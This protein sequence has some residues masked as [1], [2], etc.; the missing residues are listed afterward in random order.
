MKT[1]NDLKIGDY[2]FHKC[3]EFPLLVEPKK[4]IKHI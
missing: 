3:K 4:N 2:I 1:F